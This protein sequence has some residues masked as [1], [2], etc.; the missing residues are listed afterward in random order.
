MLL[1]R[2]LVSV[3]RLL[4]EGKVPVIVGSPEQKVTIEVEMDIWRMRKRT[5][6]TIMAAEETLSTVPPRGNRGLRN[7]I[8][9]CLLVLLDS[10]SYN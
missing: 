3:V 9:L 7:S 8:L 1:P 5:N 4:P 2:P 6:L 10:R